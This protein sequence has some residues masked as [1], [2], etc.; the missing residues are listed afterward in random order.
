MLAQIV[1][2]KQQVIQRTQTSQVSEDWP[3][4]VFFIPFVSF[5]HDSFRR[6]SSEDEQ[7]ALHFHQWALVVRNGIS[8]WWAAP[9]KVNMGHGSDLLLSAFSSALTIWAQIKTKLSSSKIIDYE[10]FIPYLR[11]KDTNNAHAL[12][13]Q[14]AI[15]LKQRLMHKCFWWL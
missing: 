6:R 4:E 12:K 1:R 13:F 5:V 7:T 14:G 8:D 10:K 3:S 15:S 11:E 2:Y 9:A